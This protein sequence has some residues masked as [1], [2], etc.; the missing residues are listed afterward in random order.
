V[1]ALHAWEETQLTSYGWVDED[2]GVIRIPVETAGEVLSRRG[3][4]ARGQVDALSNEIFGGSSPSE[5]AALAEADRGD[6]AR[7]ADQGAR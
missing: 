4:E 3:L 1:E 5:A 6:A 2:A 7:I